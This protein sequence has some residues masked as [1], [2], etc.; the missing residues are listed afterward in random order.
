MDPYEAQFFAAE[1]IKTGR[2]AGK[3]WLFLV[4]LLRGTSENKL[5]IYP[6][7]FAGGLTG[8]QKRRAISKTE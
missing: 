2:R 1:L 7:S 4:S 6:E 8:W 3:S 5:T